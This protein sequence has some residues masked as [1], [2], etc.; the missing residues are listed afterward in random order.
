[1]ETTNAQPAPKRTRRSAE[2]WHAIL[3]EHFATGETP[4]ELADRLGCALSTVE[5]QM[6]AVTA[7]ATV[8]Y[9]SPTAKGFVEV[10]KHQSGMPC[11]QRPFGC[12]QRVASSRSSSAVAAEAIWP[13][14]SGWNAGCH[15]ACAFLSL[16]NPMRCGFDK[17]GRVAEMGMRLYDGHLFAFASR[18]GEHQNSCVGSRRF[19]SLVV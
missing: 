9:A 7:P 15:A 17:L 19:R 12:V 3:N 8:R 13:R 2:Q 4:Q 6:K 5:M 16:H 10:Q 11:H 1:M 14:R 18:R